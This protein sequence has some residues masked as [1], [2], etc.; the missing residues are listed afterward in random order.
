[1]I[2]IILIDKDLQD[3]ITKKLSKP[4]IDITTPKEISDQ[5]KKANKVTITIILSI[6]ISELIYINNITDL[7][8][9]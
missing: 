9:L 3:I 5:K 6:S 8:I 1:M 2:Q 4:I 7:I